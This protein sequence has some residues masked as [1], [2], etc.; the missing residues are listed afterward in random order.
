LAELAVQLQVGREALRRVA[1]EVVAS[2]IVRALDDDCLQLMSGSWDPLLEEAALVHSAAPAKL[3]RV[4]TRIA[5]ERIRG[6]AARTFADA[7]RLRK[8]G[9]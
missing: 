7:F 9:D 1:D 2:G 8:K 3:V 6:M 4:F 5:M